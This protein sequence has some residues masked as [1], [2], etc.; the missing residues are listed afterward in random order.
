[1]RRILAIFS[2][3]FLCGC[4]YKPSAVIANNILD[5]RVFV[6]VI[7][8]SSDPQNTVAIKDALKSGI[9]ERLGKELSDKKSANT[10]I[11]AKINHLRFQEL[12]YDRLGYITSF[13]ANLSVNY[14]TKLKNGEIF[15]VNTI[16]DH[17]FRVSKLVKNVRDTNSVISDKDRFN[18]IENASKQAFDEFISAVAIKGLR[19]DRELSK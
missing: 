19:V 5:D 10:H 12:T 18:A 17:D 3:I 14:T 1:M 4:G 7:M 6:D 2:V 11:I 13:R 9:V 8:S 15:S 16:G